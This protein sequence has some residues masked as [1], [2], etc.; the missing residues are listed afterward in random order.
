MSWR[1]LGLDG[2]MTVMIIALAAVW[3]ALDALSGGL[4]LTA[5]NLY[6]LAVQSSVVGVMACGMVL[7]IVARHI[8]LSVGSLLGFTGMAIA[9]LQ[10]ELAWPWPA[11]LMAGLLLG[12]LAGAAQGVLVAYGGL[13]AF[14]VTLGGLLI[15]R[16]S[17]YLLSDGQTLAP[18]AS[19]YA[20]LGGG[21]DGSLGAQWSLLLGALAVLAVVAA[22]LRG[23]AARRAYGE[24]LPP[25]WLEA[26][27]TAVV[28]LAITA[29]V[30]V[31]NAHT[32][33]RTDVA[34]GIPIPV[35]IL[36]AVALTTTGLARAT[37]FGRYV[38][39]I[40][41][42][43]EAAELAGIDV[44]RITV[45]VF[46]WMGILCAVGAIITTARLGAGASSM[47]TLAE[48]NVIAAAVI[49]GTSLSGGRGSV[50]GAILGA[51]I[52]Q[53][54]ENG[55]VLLGVSSPLRQV[56]IGAVL[57]AAVWVDVAYARRRT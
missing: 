1:A 4:F 3:L 8:D 46:V 9:L 52:M 5:R 16:G 45:A 57:I 26:T 10:V 42:S 17:A 20:R 48:L 38:F 51:V 14:V 18:L 49:G 24:P 29:F 39:A 21:P 19:G 41:G 35:L 44:R 27:R 7:V 33:P 36:I 54:L 56:G 28:V 34:R 2:R 55:M 37:R 43:P 15:F 25:A 31:M 6:N 12:A 22:L 47:G 30:G 50:P 13:P 32:Q 53:S 23:R 11:S 40:G